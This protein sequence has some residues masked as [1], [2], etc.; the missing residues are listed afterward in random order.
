MKIKCLIV[1]DEQLARTLLSEYI[2]KIPQLELV[3]QCKNPLE[4][5]ETLQGEAIDLMFLDIQMPELTGI[6]FLKTLP[7]KPVVVFTTAYPE[8]A[9]EGYQLDVTDYL[10]KPFS[11]ERFVQSVNKASE[12]IKLKKEVK[13]GEKE[14]P[15]PLPETKVT[16]EFIIINADHKLYRVKLNDILYIEGLKEY[17]RYHTKD[18]KIIA[19]QSLKSLEESLPYEQFIRVHRSYIVSMANIKTLEGNQVE[20]AGKMIPIGKSYKEE[21]LKRIF[22]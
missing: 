3:G 9:L 11:F 5:M 13:K 17:V 10:L 6:E 14:I 21:V 22:K 8:Y 7:G 20:V 19:L 4:A 12:L 15:E 18:Q 16:E 1:D 2:S